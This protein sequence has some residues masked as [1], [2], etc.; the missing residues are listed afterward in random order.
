MEK[1]RLQKWLSSLG[2]ASR[3]E[4]ERWIE[5][6]RLTVNGEVA[7]LGTK[8]NPEEDEVKLDGKVVEHTPPPRVYWMLNKPE[9]F[10]TSRVRQFGKKDYL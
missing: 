6:G 8:V 2:V 4:A 5:K 9:K 7:S 3:R 1:I 10:L